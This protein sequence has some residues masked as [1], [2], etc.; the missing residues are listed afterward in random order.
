MNIQWTKDIPDSYYSSYT[1]YD[2]DGNRYFR[3]AEGDVFTCTTPDGRAATGWTSDEAYCLAKEQPEKCTEAKLQIRKDIRIIK[4][5]IRDMGIML[6]R[7]EENL[8]VKM[9]DLERLIFDGMTRDEYLKELKGQKH[10]IGDIEIILGHVYET[11]MKVIRQVGDVTLEL[12]ASM[13]VGDTYGQLTIRYNNR[14]EQPITAPKK[15]RKAV[16]EMRH[17]LWQFQISNTDKLD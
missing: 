6:H 4:D 8:K 3:S 13:L 15:Y 14:V 16:N 17:I 2:E 11:K 5:E 10:K 1:G 7:K 12:W 9:E